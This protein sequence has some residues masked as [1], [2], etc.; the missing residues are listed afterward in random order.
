MVILGILFS[1]FNHLL[2]VDEE[3]LGTSF[4]FF[5]PYARVECSTCVDF[6]ELG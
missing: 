6:S 3:I 5:K 4:F 1:S 2:Q